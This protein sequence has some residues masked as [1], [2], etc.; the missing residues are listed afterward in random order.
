[1]KNENVK[2]S[3]NS[4]FLLLLILVIFFIGYWTGGDKFNLFSDVDNNEQSEINLS[5]LSNDKYL[6]KYSQTNSNELSTEELFEKDEYCRKT[7]SKSFIEDYEKLLVGETNTE[8]ERIELIDVFY[9]P[10]ENECYGVY[11][12]RYTSSKY[13]NIDVYERRIAKAVSA[14]SI[15]ASFKMTGINFKEG[16]KERYISKIE[17]LKSF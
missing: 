15:V 16:E 5:D 8:W 2:R 3:N 17:E 7:Y 12:Y 14:G 6:Q 4:L 10:K 13:S 1:M 9:S 11:D